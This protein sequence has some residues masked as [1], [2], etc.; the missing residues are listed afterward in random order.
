MILGKYNL[1]SSDG[2]TAQ[3]GLGDE[4]MIGG[5]RYKY[6]LCN[7]STALAAYALCHISAAGLVTESTTTLVGTAARPTGYCI[8]QFAVAVSEYFWAPIGPFRVREDGSTTFK[9]LA[10]NAA[11]SVR[12]YTTGTAGVVDDAVTTGLVA[13]LAL[14]E[15]VTTQEAADCVAAQR[16][17]AFCEL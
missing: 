15:T 1:T 10:A 5:S 6:C 13:G 12:L 8:P 2:T 11:T 17:V 14:T 4:A 16:L 3:A 7:A 9:V